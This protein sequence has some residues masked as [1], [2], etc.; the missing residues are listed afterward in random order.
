MV[1]FNSYDFRNIQKIRIGGLVM[2]LIM[3]A[4]PEGAGKTSLVMK[5]CTKHWIP[6]IRMKVNKH[7]FN[8][9]I[10]ECSETF[11]LMLGQ[12]SSIFEREHA[13]VERGFMSSLVYSRV[14][15][16]KYDLSYIDDVIKQLDNKLKVVLLIADYKILEQRRQ[17][18]KLISH[19]DYEKL[20]KTYLEV[21]EELKE[22]GVDILIIDTTALTKAE[23]YKQAEEFLWTQ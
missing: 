23:V 16:R 3:V 14:Y 2:T 21:A 15:N 18:D 20:M 6:R 13:I 4:G 7:I 5:L 9:C 10:E 22:K 11:N 17:R 1:N 8:T 19:K 12:F